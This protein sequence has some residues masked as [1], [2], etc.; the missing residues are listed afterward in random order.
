MK[1]AVNWFLAFLLTGAL[2][3]FGISWAFRQAVA[4]ALKDGGTPVTEAVREKEMEMIRGKVEELGSIYGFDAEWALKMVTPEVLEDLNAQS[5]AWWNTLLTQGVSAEELQWD[6]ETIREQLSMDESFVGNLSEE[7]ADRKVMQ[8]EAAIRQAVVRTVLPMRG[9]LMTLIMMQAGKRAD[10]P[11]LVRFATGIPLFLLA[12]CFLL[13]GG[14]AALEGRPLSGCLKYLGCAMG[15]G[16]LVTLCALILGA[17]MPV[18]GLIGEA[19]PSLLLQY[20][21]LSSGMVLRLAVFSALLLAGCVLC[22]MTWRRKT[23][24]AGR[25]E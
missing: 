19:S 16:A 21:V 24:G 14:I 1:K 10:L 9:N 23:F 3:F 7:E 15:G 2:A 17:T 12:L 5:A 18:S 4:P 8:A 22:L 11:N 25:R 20:G 6:T 13:A